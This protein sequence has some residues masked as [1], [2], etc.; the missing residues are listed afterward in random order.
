MKA[1]ELAFEIH[2]SQSRKATSIPYLSHVLTVSATVMEFGGNEDQCIASLLHDSLEDHGSNQLIERI[3]RALGKVV[4]DL[5][6][7]CSDT[8]TKPKPP[9][10]ERKE[11]YIGKLEFISCEALLIIAADNFHNVTSIIRDFKV[12]RGELWKRFGGGKNGTVWYYNSVRQVLKKRLD[13]PLVDELS[14]AVRQ[15]NSISKS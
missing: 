5:V 4:L 3:E 2:Q 15:L 13:T 6:V 11:K 9:W 7:D 8:I 14:Q 12:H 10:R 1:L